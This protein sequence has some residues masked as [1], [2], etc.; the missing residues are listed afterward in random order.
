[1][2]TS[3]KHSSVALVTIALASIIGFASNAFAQSGA[4][5]SRPNILFI[6]ADDQGWNDL[7]VLMDD[8]IPGS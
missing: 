8:D 6:F 5:D 3:R 2:K 4:D 1:M 7:S